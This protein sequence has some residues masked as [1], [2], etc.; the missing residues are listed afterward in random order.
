M[1][2]TALFSAATALL[3]KS[4]PLANYIVSDPSSSSSSGAGSS[5]S[6]SPAGSSS[7]SDPQPFAV[8]LWR[9]VPA[10]HR[11][12]GQA[13]SVWVCEKRVLDGVRDAGRRA[14][15][16]EQMK[17]EVRDATSSDRKKG[18]MIL[19]KSLCWPLAYRSPTHSLASGLLPHTPPPPT[20]PAH[21]RA[22]RG[23]PP[24]TNMG[25]RAR[26]EQS[27][28][29]GVRRGG[30]PTA[31]ACRSGAGGGQGGAGAGYRGGE[32]RGAEWDGD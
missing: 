14:W 12:T 30:Q 24:R 32:G 3:G 25:E 16:V 27:R 26:S 20:P 5:A 28:R 7:S 15:V 6:T 29:A 22:P 4:S 19:L 9:V 10:R 31:A 11:T 21:H 8:G 23:D 18:L 2:A 13:V 1:A 17:K